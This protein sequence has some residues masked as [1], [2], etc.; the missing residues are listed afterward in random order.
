MQIAVHNIRYIV[1]I[2]LE[3][4]IL[5]LLGTMDEISK[6]KDQIVKLT[7]EKTELISLLKKA[8]EGNFDEV[9]DALSKLSLDDNPMLSSGLQALTG[10][11]LGGGVATVKTEA[12]K[13]ESEAEKTAE[14][15]KDKAEDAKESVGDA[16]NAASSLAKGFG[17]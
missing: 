4:D 2:W 5:F 7:S 16:I 13:A 14:E 3:I 6:L 10:G 11:A 9:K 12:E 8:M 15:S 1:D 17:W